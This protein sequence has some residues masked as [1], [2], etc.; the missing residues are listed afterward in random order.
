LIAIETEKE[1]RRMKM[2]GGR[3]SESGVK[4]NN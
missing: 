4:I 2:K 3:V 1:E